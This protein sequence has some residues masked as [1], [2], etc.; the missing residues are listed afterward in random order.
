MEIV[1]LNKGLN[2][3]AEHELAP[4]TEFNEG[5]NTLSIKHLQTLNGC[6]MLSL[7]YLNK[8]LNPLS[9]KDLQRSLNEI[10]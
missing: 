8:T 7:T 3:E 5:Y 4:Y 10:K 2:F 6:S 9:I 1:D